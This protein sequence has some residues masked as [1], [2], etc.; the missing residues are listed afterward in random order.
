[1][2]KIIIGIFII[3]FGVMVPLDQITEFIISPNIGTSID[4]HT[5]TTI[6]I[7]PQFIGW[8]VITKGSKD[9]ELFNNYKLFYLLIGLSV[10]GTIINATFIYIPSL[11][12]VRYLIQFIIIALALSAEYK[13]ITQLTLVSNEQAIRTNL[14]NLF[15]LRVIGEALMFIAYIDSRHLNNFRIIRL[16]LYVVIFLGYLKLSKSS[17]NITTTN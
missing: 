1:M 10:I 17:Q 7:L 3:S 11:G 8:Y 13:L 15:Y 4:V 5:Y 12:S 9:M 6:T 14:P 16:V 2:R